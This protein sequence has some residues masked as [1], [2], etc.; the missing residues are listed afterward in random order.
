[1]ERSKIDDE[2][3]NG[4]GEVVDIEDT[5]LFPLVKGSDVA[6]NR[7]EI[8][9]RY[10]LV[11]QK[12]IGESTEDIENLSPKTWE[13][14]EAHSGYLDSRKSKIYQKSSRFAIFGVGSYTFAPWKIA[15]CG[16]YKKLNFRLIGKM[17]NK[18]IIFD[19]TVYFLSFEDEQVACQTLALLTSSPAIDFYSSLIF[20]DEKRPIKSSILNSLDLSALAERL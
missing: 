7:T 16:L 13:Y 19:D 5:Y 1:M 4:L 2:F 10:V 17:N 14:L 6:Q 20:W 18:A 3:V 9:N 12:F 15:I 11:T 8:I